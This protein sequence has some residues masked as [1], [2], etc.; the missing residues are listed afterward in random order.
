MRR[1][2]LCSAF[3]LLASS[4]PAQEKSSEAIKTAHRKKTDAVVPACKDLETTGIAVDK[5]FDDPILAAIKGARPSHATSSPDS[6]G[7]N[8]DQDSTWDNLIDCANQTH[9]ESERAEALRVAAMWERWRTE[10][11]REQSLTASAPPVH[12]ASCD[13]LDQLRARVKAVTDEEPSST[14]SHPMQDYDSTLDALRKCMNESVRVSK[15]K[16]DERY[17]SAVT[18]L[19]LELWEAR[20]ARAFFEHAYLNTTDYAKAQAEYDARQK[21]SAEQNE[22]AGTDHPLSAEELAQAA[23]RCDQIITVAGLTPNGLVLYIPPEGQKFMAKNAKNYPRMCL[24]EETNAASFAPSVPHYLLVWAYSEAAFAGFQPVQQVTTAPVAGSGTLTSVYGQRW[25]FTYSGTLT[26][27][28]TVEAPYVIQSRSLYLHAYDEKGNMISQHS[29]TTSNQTG[30]DASYA[31]GY[32]AGALISLLWNNP[33]R[34]IK[35]VLRD[36]QKD[37][38]KYGKK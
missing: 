14:I 4:A 7:G 30:G 21:G 35:S 15:D 27:I 5:L 6:P 9:N 20:R 16:P 37:S 28:D 36:V 25:N 12:P 11:F 23:N 10:N 17:W 22:Q 26:E 13:N 32:N 8:I 19:S 3:L 18:L 24:V 34:L 29:V 33:S 31:A 2:I 1:A 38:M